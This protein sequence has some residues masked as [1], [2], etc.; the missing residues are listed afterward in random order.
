MPSDAQYHRKYRET[1]KQELARERGEAIR[2]GVALACRFMRQVIAG[3]AL[4]GHQAAR[5]LERAHLPQDS[6][7]VEQRKAMLEALRR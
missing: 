7:D 5:E 6:G 3:R 2:E 1:Q 4:T